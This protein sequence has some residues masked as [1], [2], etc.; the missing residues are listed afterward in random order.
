MACFEPCVSSVLTQ[1]EDVQNFHSLL[2]EAPKLYLGEGGGGMTKKIFSSS[3]IFFG[4]KS[5]FQKSGA[6]VPTA[7]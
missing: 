1:N 6:H 2:N 7:P 4:H 5:N 3:I